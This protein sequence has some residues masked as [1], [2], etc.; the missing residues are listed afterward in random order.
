MEGYRQGSAKVEEEE[1]EEKERLGFDG[2]RGGMTLNRVSF[3]LL[4]ALCSFLSD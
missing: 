4:F 3:V 2:Q 1:E